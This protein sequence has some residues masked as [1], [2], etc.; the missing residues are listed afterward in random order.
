MLRTR[1]S[2]IY[3]QYTVLFWTACKGWVQV[4]TKESNNKSAESSRAK[5]ESKAMRKRS[6]YSKAAMN[7]T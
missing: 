6:K 1:N 4:K 5:T 2:S 3:V 7:E